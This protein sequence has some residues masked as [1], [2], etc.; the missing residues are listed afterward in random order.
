MLTQSG[1][2][3]KRSGQGNREKSF[4]V[5]SNAR[6]PLSELYTRSTEEL[7][8]SD[9][10]LSSSLAGDCYMMMTHFPPQSDRVLDPNEG[11]T[12]EGEQH[13]III[14]GMVELVLDGEHIT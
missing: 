8:F 10:L 2:F 3:P 7:G 5:R 9:E 13:G 14:N 12:Y 4:V 6:R 1:F 11:F